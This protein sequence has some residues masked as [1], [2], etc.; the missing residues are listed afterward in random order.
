MNCCLLSFRT[1]CGFILLCCV[2][3]TLTELLSG[4]RK[5]SVASV[6]ND[7]IVSKK[8]GFVNEGADL[9]DIE[10]KSGDRSRMLQHEVEPI[11]EQ[12]KSS[13]QIL[14]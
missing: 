1:L 9:E 10:P 13:L 6:Q 14:V 8:N 4:N 3:G 2:L 11:I 7:V 12:G 5:L